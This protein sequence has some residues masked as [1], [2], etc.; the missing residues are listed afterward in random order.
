V[1]M[2]GLIRLQR[3]KKD[4]QQKVNGNTDSRPLGLTKCKDGGI[5]SGGRK[6]EFNKSFGK[7]PPFL[8]MG[9]RELWATGK[10]W[11]EGRCHRGRIKKVSG[12]K[13]QGK[14]P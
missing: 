2:R 9:P 8:G 12:G 4:L 10:K 11:G 6:H 1:G 13:G 3:I 5:L 14:M 7:G